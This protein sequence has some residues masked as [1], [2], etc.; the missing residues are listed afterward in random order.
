MKLNTR[1]FFVGGLTVAMVATFAYLWPSINRVASER[2]AHN[3]LFL[4]AE[5]APSLAEAKGFQQVYP[6]ND[7]MSV[8]GTLPYVVITVHPIEKSTRH[9]IEASGAKI[10]SHLAEN[11]VLVEAT[12]QVCERLVAEPMI[13]SMRKRMPA[14]KV[15]PELQALLDSGVNEAEVAILS[16]DPTDIGDLRNTVVANGGEILQGCLNDETSFRAKV[17]A[18]LVA[19]L[20]SR[21]AVR[22]LEHYQRPQLMNDRA[23]AEKVMNVTPMWNTLGLTGKGQ[24]VTTSDSG[25]STGT[26]ESGEV[27][28]NH[29]DLMEQVI[30]FKVVENCVTNDVNGHGTHTAG[31][32]VGNGSCSTNELIRGSAYGAKLWAWFCSDGGNAV[33][34]PTSID[35]LLQPVPDQFT[36]YIHSASWGRDNQGAYD[37][38]C[39]MFDRYLWQHP[40][41]LPVIAAGN[42]GSASG[43][44][45]SPGSAKNVLGVGA[46]QNNR[47]GFD[48]G[49]GNGDTTVTAPFSSRGPCKSGRIK[50]DIAA[51]GV[52]IL[53][54]RSLGVDYD[55]GIYD[56][57]YAYDSGTSMAC[58]LTAGAVTLVRQW[59]VEKMGYDGEEKEDGTKKELPTAALMKA[60]ITGGAKGTLKPNNAQ[61]WGRVDLAETLAPTNRAVKLIDRIPFAAD[62]EFVYLIQTTNEAPIDVQLAWVDYP[63]KELVNDLDLKVEANVGGV[64]KLWYGNGGD[65]P[66]T[67]NNLEAVRLESAETAT[68]IIT[69]NCK[70]IG[71]D[72]NEGGAA[73]LYIRGAFDPALEP[74]EPKNVR[75]RETGKEYRLL[76][77]ALEEVEAGQTIELLSKTSLRKAM[78]VAVDCTICA[79]ND[80]AEATPVKFNPDAQLTV[81]PGHSLTLTNFCLE[82]P[83][84]TSVIVET[85]AVLKIAGTVAL[86]EIELKDATGLDLA[87]KISKSIYVTTPKNAHSTRFATYSCDFATE[88]GS[89]MYLLNPDDDELGGVAQEDG[90]IIWGVADV[91]DDV[92]AVRLEQGSELETKKNFRS[93]AKLLQELPEIGE[94][95]I[96]IIRNQDLCKPITVTQKLTIDGDALSVPVLTVIDGAKFTCSAGGKLVL[97]KVTVK[98]NENDRHGNSE[99]ITIE[100]D[101]ALILSEGA[102]V[103]DHKTTGFCKAGA[104][105]LCGGAMTME[106]GSLITACNAAG[107]EG[108]GGGVRVEDGT[109]ALN[110]GAIVNCAATKFGTSVWVDGGSNVTARVAFQGA[111]V[112]E[113]LFVRADDETVENPKYDPTE[114]LQLIGPIEDGAH[115]AVKYEGLDA[116]KHN[117]FGDVFAHVEP[118]LELDEAA[119]EELRKAFVNGWEPLMGAAL[120]DDDHTLV[121]GE[122]VSPAPEPGDVR[123]ITG[124]EVQEFETLEEA[125]GSI[126]ADCR[127]EIVAGIVMWTNDLAVAHNVVLTTASDNLAGTALVMHQAGVINVKKSAAL[128]IENIAIQGMDFFGTNGKE[129]INVA[130]GELTL[131]DRTSI[132]NHWGFQNSNSAVIYVNQGKVTMLEGSKISGSKNEYVDTLKGNHGFAGAIDARS[133][134]VV[135]LRGGTITGCDSG[136]AGAVSLRSNTKGY[137]GGAVKIHH[138]S[139]IVGT[140]RYSDL[141]VDSTST[142]SL[143]SP[144]TAGADSIGRAY[145][146]STKFNSDFDYVA[147]I[148]DFNTWTNEVGTIEKLLASLDAFFH[149]TNPSATATLVTN[150]TKKAKALIVWNTALQDGLYT[151]KDGTVYAACEG[152]KPT[153]LPIAF[154]AISI[155]EDDQR[156]VLTFETAVKGCTYTIWGSPT[157]KA[158]DFTVVSTVNHDESDPEITVNIPKDNNRFWKATAE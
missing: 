114:A 41:Y 50:P 83:S 22:Y 122:G 86:G 49:W 79:T 45:G 91:P 87:G 11:E 115:I 84:M 117:N 142:L 140:S 106:A 38:E 141:I 25:I 145:D 21:G 62:K 17:P 67:L 137:I 101:G 100:K 150:A 46:T 85:N 39:E 74:E 134:S 143:A 94:V 131:G 16:L 64:E 52:G 120:N 123:V 42:D 8:R 110:G 4:I 57:Y 44:I 77:N 108:S 54:T 23:V 1:G 148:E 51:P 157:L 31:S 113:D 14:D 10:V 12:P 152:L 144:L 65:E 37:S 116:A 118:S 68:Y 107:N 47:E 61:G 40:E 89:A 13:A 15:D 156:V 2:E 76:D 98:G 63:G 80:N 28:I 27:V 70:R 133:A 105:R 24:I 112:V 136:Y 97:S 58:P 139:G 125:F 32:I 20:A 132:S 35:D 103:R 34:T 104:V 55:Y 69:V 9:M 96:A 18:G 121:W 33:Y 138:N 7:T 6:T 126:T 149:D 119:T 53:S 26:N 95:K 66:D 130:E 30:G 36:A 111:P 109:L 151:A 29:P 75:I 59:L 78:T 82:N 102:T 88:A 154:T 153:P 5:D 99:L 56:D 71:Y 19:T 127:V 72:Y 128:T 146:A 3:D 147:E 129:M 124:K 92:A 60:V 48:G 90:T 155:D 93:L 81:A 73:A 158:E 135:D 43:T